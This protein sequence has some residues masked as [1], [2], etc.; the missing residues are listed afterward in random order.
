MPDPAKT[1]QEN[2]ESL[3][4]YIREKEATFHMTWDRDNIME[5]MLLKPASC[6]ITPS[7]AAPVHRKRSFPCQRRL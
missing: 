3:K 5:E 1:E 4:Q 6:W 7:R 2:I